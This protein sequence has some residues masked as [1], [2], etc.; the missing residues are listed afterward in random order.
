MIPSECIQIAVSLHG[1]EG[2]IEA[3][4]WALIRCAAILTLGRI[5]AALIG[6]FGK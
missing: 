3:L 6:V 5:L 1:A 2:A 4:G